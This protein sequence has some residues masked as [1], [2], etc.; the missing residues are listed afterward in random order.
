MARIGWYQQKDIDS[1]R[2]LFGFDLMV[3]RQQL[4]DAPGSG[5]NLIN[6]S[7]QIRCHQPNQFSMD[8]IGPLQ[9]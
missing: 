1:Y 4:S 3:Y 9:Q 7:R 8:L 6:A 2:A 5:D